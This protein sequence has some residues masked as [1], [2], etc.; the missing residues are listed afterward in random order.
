MTLSG[1]DTV[2]Y[3]VTAINGNVESFSNTI[4]AAATAYAFEFG[5][6]T[7]S[8]GQ[9]WMQLFDKPYKQLHRLPQPMIG[10]FH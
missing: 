8:T 3:V 6:V 10:L 9:V 5:K 7:S 2:Y 4:P 1:T